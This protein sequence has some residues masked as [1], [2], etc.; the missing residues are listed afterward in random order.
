MLGKIE[1]GQT[2]KIIAYLDEFV[3]VNQDTLKQMTETINPNLIPNGAFQEYEKTMQ[4]T[5]NDYDTIFK[6][7]AWLP[8]DNVTRESSAV[9]HIGKYASSDG[10]TM[11][12]VGYVTLDGKEYLYANDPS[13]RIYSWQQNSYGI[14][15]GNI[16]ALDYFKTKSIFLKKRYLLEKKL[17]SASQRHVDVPAKDE[18]P[19]SF[20][21]TLKKNPKRIVPR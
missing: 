21:E 12:D 11:Y 9:R 5:I 4:N 19:L 10:K 13:E 2:D 15:Y 20:S 17:K 8:L 18:T 14:Y 6:N 3:I 7:H 16:V 1:K